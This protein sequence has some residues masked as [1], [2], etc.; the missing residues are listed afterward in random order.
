MVVHTGVHRP[1]HQHIVDDLGEARQ[2]FRDRRSTVTVFSKFP[3]AAQDPGTG[4]GRVVVLDRAGELLPVQAPCMNI[5]IIAVACG[6]LRGC[7]G[8][9]SND[10]RANSGLTGAASNWSRWLAHAAA[11]GARLIAPRARK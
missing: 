8:N 3:R 11:N 2:Q 9:R 5:E 6:V 4:L 1:D 10:C 7:L